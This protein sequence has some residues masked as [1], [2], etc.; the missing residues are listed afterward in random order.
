MKQK[1]HLN[2]AIIFAGIITFQQARAGTTWDGTGTGTNINTQENWNDNLNPDFTGSASVTFTSANSTAT[3]N[4]DVEFTKVTFG[5]SFTIASGA[6]NFVLRGSTSGGTANLQSNSGASNVQINEQLLIESLSPTVGSQ[7]TLLTINNNRNAVDT[8][9]LSINNG[10]ALAAGSTATYYDIRYANGSGGL[11]DTRIAGTISGLGTLANAG[12]VWTGDLIIAGN[13]S[14]STSNIVISSGAGYGN[15]TS[16]ARL[17]LGETTSDSQTWNGITLNNT[18]ALAVGGNITAGSLSIGGSASAANTRI[19]GYSASTSSLSLAGGNATANVT[20][21]GAGTNQ[22]NLA[23]V[24][25]GISATTI[26]NASNTYAGGTVAEAS[27]GSSALI[28][29]ASGAFG[30][31]GLTIGNAST[32]AGNTAKV[33][34]NGFNQTVSFLTSGGVGTRTLE[35]GSATLNSTLTVNQASDTSFSGLIQNGA[36]G[37]LKL[38]KSGDGT[39]TLSNTAAN[40]FTGGLQIDGGTLAFS[41]AN[42]LGNSGTTVPNLNGGTLKYTGATLSTD[43][44]GL[45]ITAASV[46]E[47]SS[48]STTLRSGGNLS[49]SGQLTINGP[50]VV[51]LGK[52]SANATYGNGFTGNIVVSNGATLSLRNQNSMGSDAGG[53]AAGT[54]TI[55]NGGTLLLDP[56]SQ[57]NV[58]YN[59]ET[60]AFQGTSTLTNRLN[61]QASLATAITGAVSTAGTLT[62]NTREDVATANPVSIELSGAITG[63]GGINFGTTGGRAGTYIVSNISNGYLGATNVKSGTL[64]VNGNISTSSLTTV[65]SGATLGGSGTVGDLTVLTG[66]SLNPGN[67]PGQLTVDGNFSQAGTLNLEITGLTAG[68]LHD[69]VNVL[70]TVTLGGIFSTNFSGFTP[71][72]GNLIFILLNDGADAVSGTFSSLAQNAVV[73]NFGGF[74]WKISYTANSGTG[75][76]TGGNDVALMAVPEPRAAII[77]GLGMLALLR[78]RRK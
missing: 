4:T 72:N 19:V 14:L 20:L 6:G 56:F 73:T 28:L 59:A 68:T 55:Q 30:T 39:L 8:T 10:I 75:L 25:R 36:A 49:G 45:E 2:T 23:I 35:N 64:L 16:A 52:N 77:G 22:N 62:V 41:A 74:D 58:S 37:T 18:M 78:R 26:S 65:E 60:I 43:N 7:G 61:G 57:T 40:T 32:G 15:P 67:S 66:G 53:F 70:G 69:Q 48:S 44:I 3:V 1:H 13:Q 71:A 24:H 21:G 17:V 34:L 42:Q 63:S 29:G 50:G 47:V 27:G 51:A 11:G 31:G 9:A 46:V 33:Q 12:S 5:G 76:F 54:T 38:V